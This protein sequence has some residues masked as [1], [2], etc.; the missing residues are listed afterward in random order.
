[1]HQTRCFYRR[2]Q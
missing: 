2:M 1:V